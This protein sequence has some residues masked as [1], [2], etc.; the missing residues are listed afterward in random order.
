MMNP[1]SKTSGVRYTSE[2]GWELYA[3][4]RSEE[5]EIQDQEDG[6]TDTYSQQEEEV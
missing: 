3:N 1:P 5:S 6:G 2:G 4:G